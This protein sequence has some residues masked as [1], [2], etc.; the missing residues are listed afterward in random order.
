MDCYSEFPENRL[1]ELHCGTEYVD[2][3]VC[4]HCESKN[5]KYIKKE[6]KKQ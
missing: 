2:A 4:P 6:V 5:W 1:V 3:I